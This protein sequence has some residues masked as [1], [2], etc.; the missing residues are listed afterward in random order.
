MRLSWQALLLS[1]SLLH[2]RVLWLNN[3]TRAINLW[4]LRRLKYCFC[5]LLCEITTLY[6]HR[7]WSFD[8]F[9]ISLHLSCKSRWT[10]SANYALKASIKVLWVIRINNQKG[11]CVKCC[12]TVLNITSSAV[13]GT[14]RNIKWGSK[15]WFIAWRQLAAVFTKTSIL[16]SCFIQINTSP[17]TICQRSYRILIISLC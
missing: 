16:N 8:K 6:D 11:D 3:N 1:F 13:K 9:F 2:T 12:W 10:T 7:R 14:D 5:S 17:F 15:Y 4:L